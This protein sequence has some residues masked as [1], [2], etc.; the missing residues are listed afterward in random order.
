MAGRL[1]KFSP[2]ERDQGVSAPGARYNSAAP[3]GTITVRATS[4]RMING[5]GN[6]EK[7]FTMVATTGRA[8]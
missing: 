7:D 5:F 8:P 4:Y 2:G 1:R 3:S 6:R